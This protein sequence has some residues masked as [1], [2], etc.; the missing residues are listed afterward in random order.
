MSP[1]L[2]FDLFLVV[3][4]SLRVEVVHLLV[5]LSPHDVH[6]VPLDL[7]DPVIQLLVVLQK[8]LRLLRLPFRYQ[9]VQ[10]LLRL[11]HLVHDV[12][13]F[14]VEDASLLPVFVLLVV[15][16]VLHFLL[17]L[18]NLLDLLLELPLS[19][20]VLSFLQSYERLVVLLLLLLVR[21]PHIGHRLALV[22]RA[23]EIVRN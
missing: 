20:L 6:L 5:V 14:L 4:H 13:V 8:L 9:L 12:V 22:A 10:L 23:S 18:P 17:E 16:G 11:L 19:L 7:V 3:F 21:V 2:P 1:G 15:Q